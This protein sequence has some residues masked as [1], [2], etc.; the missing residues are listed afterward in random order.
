MQINSVSATNFGLKK[1][2][3][4]DIIFNSA[5][6]VAKRQATKNPQIIEE[7]D[8]LIKRIQ[9]RAPKATLQTTGGDFRVTKAGKEYY[10]TDIVPG[11]GLIN[12]LKNL[13]IKLKEFDRDVKAG[14]IS[15]LG[16][17]I[18]TSETKSFPMINITEVEQN[19]NLGKLIKKA[20]EIRKKNLNK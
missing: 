17:L 1:G 13:D 12:S 10:M 9:K 6:K 20:L 15:N 14:K 7:T 11:E 16:T 4:I 5:K 18:Q 2:A 19:S 8:K 3:C